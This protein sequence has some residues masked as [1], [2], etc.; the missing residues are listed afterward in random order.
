MLFTAR[1]PELNPPRVNALAAATHTV[2]TKA[3]VKGERIT[4]PQRSS[5]GGRGDRP[6]I[7]GVR[8]SEFPQ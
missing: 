7:H 1:D 5:G 8:A 2:A 6:L 4:H 3:W